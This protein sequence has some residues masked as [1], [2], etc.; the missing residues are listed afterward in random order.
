ML[1][2]K[3]A[4]V[5]C[6]LYGHINTASTTRMW[7]WAYVLVV[8]VAREV[9]SNSSP[10]IKIGV[11]GFSSTSSQAALLRHLKSSKSQLVGGNGVTL[12]ERDDAVFALHSLDADQSQ[13]PSDTVIVHVY[14][15]AVQFN[16]EQV[17]LDLQ[18]AFGA[19]LSAEDKKSV[20]L[21][22]DGAAEAQVEAAKQALGGLVAEAWEC[23]DKPAYRSSDVG[24][25][26]NVRVVTVGELDRDPTLLTAVVDGVVAEIGESRAEARS[27]ERLF[28]ASG[29]GSSA[30][31]KTGP[32]PQQLAGYESVLEAI[33]EALSEAQRA[34]Q[35]SAAKL[36]RPEA[37]ASF[38][39]FVDNLVAMA[40]TTFDAAARRGVP[41][42]GQLSGLL[43]AMGQAEVRRKIFTMLLPFF[44]RQVQLAR[45]EVVSAFNEAAGDELPMTI[46]LMEDLAEA[47]GKALKSLQAKCA[48][49]L[50]RHAPAGTWTA[51]YDVAQLRDVLDEYIAGR[52]AQAKVAGVLSRGRKPVSVSVHCFAGH[53]L[54]RDYRQDPLGVWGDK[55]VFDEVLL[56]VGDRSVGALRAR[57]ALSQKERSESASFFEARR[58]ARDGEFAREMLMLPLSIKNPEVALMAGRGKKK[59]A[60]AT[61]RIDPER[62]Q[63]GPERFMRWDL[64]PLTEA[65]EALDRVQREASAAE[66]QAA[67]SKTVKEK[68]AG[69]LKGPLGFYDHP[70]VNYGPRMQAKKW[71]PQ[72]ES[73]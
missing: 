46:R 39:T 10:I 42:G 21:L 49:L 53:P 22:L 43:L 58:L 14:A 27:I 66:G 47:R 2:P 28:P 12:V 17:L 65:R 18:R 61:A 55:P 25:E 41:K 4:L 59:S 38:A 8:L 19:V 51:Q 5:M 26:A 56:A 31:P 35:A 45:V 60:A 62:P 54:G 33:F 23:M 44:R 67:A 9:A 57:A 11:Y 1:L 72:P 73:S 16:E 6:L 69:L 37:A 3:A 20:V 15:S 68:V 32:S 40:L 71:Q 13:I 48:A 70:P 7:I 64:A 30:K 63:T 34:A 50:T 29:A 36:Q 24:K 52:E